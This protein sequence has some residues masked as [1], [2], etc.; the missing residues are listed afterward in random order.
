M[1][2]LWHN[3]CCTFHGRSRGML[4]EQTSTIHQAKSRLMEFAQFAPTMPTQPKG[5]NHF[6]KKILSCIRGPPSKQPSCQCRQG[7]ET[8]GGK[9]KSCG[10]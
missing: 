3:R 9:V 6:F 10:L 5:D 2:L 4:A 7:L 1:S 8:F